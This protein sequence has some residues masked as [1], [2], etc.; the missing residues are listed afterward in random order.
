MAVL[1]GT[2]PQWGTPPSFIPGHLGLAGGVQVARVTSSS[3]WISWE[4]SA[5]MAD[6]LDFGEQSELGYCEAWLHPLYINTVT[7]IISIS[8]CQSLA[9]RAPL[10]VPSFNVQQDL[11]ET[12]GYDRSVVVDTVPGS[13]AGYSHGF[14]YIFPRPVLHIPKHRR[15]QCR[16]WPSQQLPQH[17]AQALTEQQDLLTE[18]WTFLLPNRLCAEEA[19]SAI[20]CGGC[21][22]VNW[23]LAESQAHSTSI[24]PF[25]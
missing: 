4:S 23:L 16:S 14:D 24:S 22:N 11:T 25:F 9:W 21:K 20:V 18:Q 7:N 1:L 8:R 17:A 13:R 19:Y 15:K 12:Q 2:R 5:F 6:P 3:T 10:P